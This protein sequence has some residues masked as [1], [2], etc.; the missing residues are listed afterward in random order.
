M[1]VTRSFKFGRALAPWAHIAETLCIVVSMLLA[2]LFVP[3]NPPL[4]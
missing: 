4:S 1:I 2:A 3:G